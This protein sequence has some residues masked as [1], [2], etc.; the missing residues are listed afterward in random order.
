MCIRDRKSAGRPRPSRRAPPTHPPPALRPLRPPPPMHPRPP[1]P[2]RLPPPTESRATVGRP[3]MARDFLIEIGTEELPASAC[4]A[5]L[6]L[7]PERVAGLFAAD[8]IDL[9]TGSLRVMVSPRRI[10]VL[11]TAVPE[12]QTPRENVQRGLPVSYTHLRAHETPE[13]LVCRLLLEK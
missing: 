3:D 7:L 1:L 5:V 10:A 4:G 13:H 8:D 11:I 12:I 2:A 6:R 9:E